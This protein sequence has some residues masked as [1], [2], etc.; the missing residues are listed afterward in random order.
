MDAKRVQQTIVLAL[1]LTLERV[2]EALENDKPERAI[3]QALILERGT[4]SLT[5]ILAKAQ[6]VTDEAMADLRSETARRFDKASDT[7]EVF[8][9]EL[10][11]A[12]IEQRNNAKL[13]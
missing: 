13:N 1:A 3:E 4:S 12:L 7:T 11:A 6:N 5:A 9:V 2:F 10:D 8:A